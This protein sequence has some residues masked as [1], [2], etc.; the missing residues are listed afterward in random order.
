[1]QLASKAVLL[2]RPLPSTG[3]QASCGMLQQYLL[4]M[5][6]TQLRAVKWQMHYGRQAGQQRQ[7]RM[8][9][10]HLFLQRS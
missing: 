4:L 1:M 10:K 3:Q 8:R 7:Q 2:H 5:L 9:L 6:F